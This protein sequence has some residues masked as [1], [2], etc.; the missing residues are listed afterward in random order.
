MNLDERYIQELIA[1]FFQVSLDLNFFRIK[2]WRKNKVFKIEADIGKNHLLQM[3]SLTPSNQH[4]LDTVE[5]LTE[6]ENHL[7]S[8]YCTFSQHISN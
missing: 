1:L 2:I 6:N 4:K 7:L 3:S 8:M 5:L